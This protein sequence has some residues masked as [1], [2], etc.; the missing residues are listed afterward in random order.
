VN[1]EA[2]DDEAPL[3]RR[4]AK[5]REVRAA[6]IDAALALFARDGFEAT[7]MDDIA[8]RAGVSRRTVFRYFPS[9]E[10]LTAPGHRGRIRR[11]EAMLED[12]APG[13]AP[14]TV[15]SRAL[16]EIAGE[17][18]DR[19]DE[20]VMVQRIVDASPAAYAYERGLDRDWE[21]AIE[22]ALRAGRRGKAAQRRARILA[23]ALM[24]VIRTT[25]REWVDEGG[26]GDLRALG[27][28]NLEILRVAMNDVGP[29]EDE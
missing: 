6:I 19:V 9:K 15:V 13:E 3:G 1:A 8:A 26:R 12:P 23:A 11:F 2:Y 21:Q 29:D 22:H 24:G 20:A 25:L 7:T 27:A 28:D 10:A 4:E 17:Y 16:L 14:F 18:M 5:K